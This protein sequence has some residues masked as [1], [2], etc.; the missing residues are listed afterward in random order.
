MFEQALA[1]A[2]KSDGN[3]VRV[4]AEKLTEYPE[5]SK[6][7]KYLDGLLLLGTARPLKAIELLKEASEEPSIRAR[8]LLLL[9]SA[10]AQSEKYDQAI[11]TF[12][13]ALKEDEGSNDV[14]FRLAS[15][16]KELLAFD[17][18]VSQLDV[19]ISK[20]FK[21]SE[22]LRMRA[23]IRVDQRKFAEAVEDYE[24]AIRADKNNPINSL[25]AERLIQ[26]FLKLQNLKKA[27]EYVGLADQSPA[28]A[29]LE[30]EKLLQSGD[31]QKIAAVLESLRTNAAFDPRTHI[32]YGR[33]MLHEVT[34]EK[35]AEGLAGLQTGL[36]VVTRNAELYKVVVE[37][38]RA[39]GD[40]KMA[41]AAQQNVDQ[42]QE[43]D[44]QFADQLALVSASRSG[45]D[46]RLKLAQLAQEIGL[47]DFAMTVCQSLSRSFPERTSDIMAFQDKLFAA[48]PPLVALPSAAAQGVSD[49]AQPAD[50]GKQGSNPPAA[51]GSAALPAAESTP[52]TEPK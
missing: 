37:L 34:S 39:A 44:K 5:Y 33:M 31:V 17:Q 26:G 15:I 11:E 23:D 29:F 24:A 40:E 51:N 3:A 42:L 21:L 38:A 46:E 35:A 32:I 41:L 20:E 28:K 12:E 19:L 18:A 10:Y 7:K 16:Y 2:E 36:R 6:K 50:D 47:S 48:L 49:P 22:T 27:E 4:A 52:P 8:S 14:R 1:A 25:I 9:G 45:Y 30:A 13:N 43:F